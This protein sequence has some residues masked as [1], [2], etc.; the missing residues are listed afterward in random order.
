MVKGIYAIDDIA[1]W[2]VD[3]KVE[4]MRGRET[5]KIRLIYFQPRLPRYRVKQTAS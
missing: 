3:K 2:K 4:A 1:D 5:Y